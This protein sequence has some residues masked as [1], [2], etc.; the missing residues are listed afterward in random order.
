METRL[1]N[2]TLYHSICTQWYE[3]IL[4]QKLGNIPISKLGTLI[5]LKEKP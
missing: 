5:A 2:F 1:W 4:K 3:P